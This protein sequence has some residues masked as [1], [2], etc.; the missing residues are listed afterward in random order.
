MDVLWEE[1]K[2]PDGRPS[3]RGLWRGLTAN[4]LRVYTRPD[5]AADL[6]NKLLPTRLLALDAE[7]LRGE[8]E[9]AR[10]A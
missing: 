1:R 7:G 10:A 9:G 5:L 8:P 2:R 6:T 3:G 4:Y